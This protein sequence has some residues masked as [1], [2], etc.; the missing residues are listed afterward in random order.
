MTEGLVLQYDGT[1]NSVVDGVRTHLAA[2][3]VLANLTGN[4]KDIP[5]PSILDIEANAFYSNALKDNRPSVKVSNI[6]FVPTVPTELTTEYAAQ[7]VRWVYT[8]NY[9]NLQPPQ[10]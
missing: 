8:D 1:D 9:A 6:P 7:F 5:T 2:P 3:T 4:G 10:R